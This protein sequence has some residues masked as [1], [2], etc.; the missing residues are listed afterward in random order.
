[1]RHSFQF[2]D[3]FMFF[4]HSPMTRKKAG[5]KDEYVRILKRVFCT[6]INVLE[7]STDYLVKV[8]WH[9]PLTHAF[10]TLLCFFEERIV[11]ATIKVSLLK[12]HCNMVDACINGFDYDMIGFYG[13]CNKIILIMLTL[14]SGVSKKD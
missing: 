10:T 13:L 6:S 1:M 12:M 14:T 9:I 4:S 3:S 7:N 5:L 11:P 2:A 8:R